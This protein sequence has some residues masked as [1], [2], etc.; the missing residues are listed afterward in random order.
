MVYEAQAFYAPRCGKYKTP[1]KATLPPHVPATTDP[2]SH[3]N[4]F[5]ASFFGG[6]CLFFGT[7]A[8]FGY[9]PG[10]SIGVMMFAQLSE[11]FGAIETGL[12]T[13]SVGVI[14]V[15]WI[16]LSRPGVATDG[17]IGCDG[18]SDGGD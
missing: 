11:R 2:M 7:C 1:H 6:N 16:L 18:G 17:G 8:L 9:F 10:E 12:G 5:W 4:M 15:I 3:A 13:I 14:L